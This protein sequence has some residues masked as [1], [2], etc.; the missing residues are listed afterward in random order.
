MNVLEGCSSLPGTRGKVRVKQKLMMSLMVMLQGS[1]V[2][3]VL[4]EGK[5]TGS[6][7]VDPTLETNLSPCRTLRAGPEEVRG[8]HWGKA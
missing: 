6:A 3:A 1:G 2:P 4:P 8:K 5:R 7:A